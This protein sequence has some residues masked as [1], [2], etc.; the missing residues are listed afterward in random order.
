MRKQARPEGVGDRHPKPGLAAESNDGP[1]KP[2]LARKKHTA[3]ART[4]TVAARKAPVAAQEPVLK[5]RA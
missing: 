5:G 2:A 3:T 1:P 4:H